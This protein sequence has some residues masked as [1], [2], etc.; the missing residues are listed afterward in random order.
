VGSHTGW[1]ELKEAY[2]ATNPS[3]EQRDRREW[4]ENRASNRDRSDLE[5]G[6]EATWNKA[7]IN[8]NLRN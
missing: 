2:R 3:K 1:H 4:F 5:N 6:W 7:A 8:A